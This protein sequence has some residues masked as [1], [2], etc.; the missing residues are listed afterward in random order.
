VQAVVVPVTENKL[1][2]AISLPSGSEQQNAQSA[3]SFASS[4][5]GQTFNN[6]QR[7][8]TQQWLPIID[9]SGTIAPTATTPFSS[10]SRTLAAG[11]ASAT[12]RIDLQA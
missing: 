4:T 8:P 11:A 7:Q 1:H 5:G 9:E 2:T 10:A 3:Q 6:Q 12:T